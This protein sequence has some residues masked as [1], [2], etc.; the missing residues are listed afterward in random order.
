MADVF[1]QST[2]PSPAGR[3][4]VK[5]IFRGRYSPQP[6]QPEGFEQPIRP[7]QSPPSTPPAPP[8]QPEQPKPSPEILSQK[9]EANNAENFPNIQNEE[10]YYPDLFPG[11]PRP[12]AEEILYEWQAPSRPYKQRD[13]QFF[14]TVG[15]IAILL[16]LILFFAGQWVAIAVVLALAF[17]IYVFT[18]IPPQTVTNKITTYG[19]RM[20]KELY[21]WD[22]LGWFWFT[23]KYD[24]E[25]VNIEVGRFPNRLALL[26]GKA[27][28]D[29]IGLI[30]SEV[31]LENEPP[32]TYFEKASLW[33]QEK[34]PLD[35]DK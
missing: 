34:I 35:L 26:I 14:S 13:K 31:L 24:D 6:A 15:M 16:S 2:I 29:I 8:D 28:K 12:V 32:P 30:L 7:M 21:Y 17:M 23:K 1:V 10:D 9:Q 11:M 33:L 27:E 5:D 18:T 19:I 25:V 20:E 3:P 4:I 22:E